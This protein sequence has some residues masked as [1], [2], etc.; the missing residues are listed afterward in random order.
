MKEEWDG[1]PVRTRLLYVLA[2]VA[3]VLVVWVTASA[4]I[5]VGTPR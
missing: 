2:A 5:L 3:L 1:L 4:Y